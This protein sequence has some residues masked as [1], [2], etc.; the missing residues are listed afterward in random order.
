[1]GHR[2]AV[3]LDVGRP[4]EAVQSYRR[5]LA[6]KPAP[7]I[8]SNLIVALNFDPV[9]V[10]ADYQ[11]ERLQWDEQFARVFAADIARH[12]NLP[13]PDRRLRIG[14]ISGSVRRQTAI[15]ALARAI[16]F[17]DTNT[18]ETV[19]YAGADL[20]DDISARMRLSVDLWRDI[21]GHSDDD[22]AQLIR[23]D[24]VDILVDPLGHWGGQRLLV[25]ARKPAPIQVTG[26][27][28]PTGTGLA[29]MDYLLADPVL[30]PTDQRHLLVERSRPATSV[31][32]RRIADPSPLP[33]T[34]RGS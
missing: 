7:D 24:N 21:E 26:W 12:R 1:L 30:V 2:G 31:I 6:I 9:A 27:G 29:T 18:F 32:G 20:D 17:C 15:D 25:F 33:A 11:A 23:Q 13:D 8:H 16:L 22:V 14:Y 10:A 3:L 28:D 19:F 34:E 5:A 4:G